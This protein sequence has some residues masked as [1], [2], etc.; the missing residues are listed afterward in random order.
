MLAPVRNAFQ[1]LSTWQCLIL[2]MVMIVVNFATVMPGSAAPLTD[3]QPSFPIRAAFYYPWFPES[4]TQQG[5]YPYTNYN[6]SSG[7]YDLTSQAIL[8][9]L[10]A[11]QYAGIQAGIASW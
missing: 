7:F 3:I 11:M 8:G 1:K 9:Q 5:I 10:I 6:P 4:W 2:T